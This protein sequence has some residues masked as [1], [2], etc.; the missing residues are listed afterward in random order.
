MDIEQPDDN[1]LKEN[2]YIMTEVYSIGQMS[3]VD[4]R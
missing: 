4:S 3:F 2:P 1:E